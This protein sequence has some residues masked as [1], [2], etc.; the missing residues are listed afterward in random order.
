MKMSELVQAAQAELDVEAQVIAKE[1]IKERLE[2]VAA[3]KRV[4]SR[5]EAQLNDLLAQ[6]VND[7]VNAG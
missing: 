4:L 5:M 6:D 2:E 1:I 3:A 7:I